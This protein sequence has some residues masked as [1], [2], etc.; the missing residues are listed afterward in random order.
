MNIKTMFMWKFFKENIEEYL[1]K[2][3]KMEYMVCGRFHSMILSMLYGQ[4]IYNLT[5][6]KKQ[7]TV[8]EESNFFNRYQPIRDMNYETILRKYYFKRA[9]NYKLKKVIKEAENQFNDLEDWIKNNHE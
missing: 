2:Y 8:I 7:E 1:E 4:K 6:S 9:S 3:A 5:Y